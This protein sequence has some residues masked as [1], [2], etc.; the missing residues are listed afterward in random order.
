MKKIVFVT[1]TRADYG[2]LKSVII[3]TQKIKKFK[4]SIFVTGMHN[5]NVYGKTNDHIKKDNIKNIYKF[6]NQ[7]IGD[8]HDKI[9]SKTIIGFSNFVKKIK[10][11]LVII[12]GDRS[13]P[14]ACAIICC[15][16]NIKIA[17]F[18][19][20]ELSG[21]VDE[22]FRHSIS[23]LC[24]IH[25]VSNSAAKK[26]L[27]QM[28]ENRKNIFITGSPDIDL[29]LS[30]KLPSLNETNQRYEL[31]FKKFSIAIFHPVTPDISNLKKNIRM[32]IKAL[33]LSKKNYVVIYPNNDLGSKI[34]INELK[35]I[36]INRVKIFPSLRF[37]NY[38][39]LLKNAEFIIGNSSSGIIEAPYYGVPTINIGERQKNR[40]NIKSIIDCGYNSNE[41]LKAINKLDKKNYNK[42]TYFFGHGD[43]D[44][45]VMKIL[46]TSSI[47][48]TSNH[49]QFLEIK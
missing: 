33:V 22:M 11:D 46:L 10:P 15:L 18:E 24:N 27:L 13:E 20:G 42:K 17:H 7:N 16:N 40:A 21:T 32:F 2:K 29:I 38:L 43:S 28:G 47:W 23:K 6:F 25:F 36:T 8:D 34:I 31:K 12:H 48:K 1:A 3:R 19:G 49:K 4:T 41:I 39:T 44:K 45:K 26:R 14:L 5:M 37:E 9:L 35:K 30:K